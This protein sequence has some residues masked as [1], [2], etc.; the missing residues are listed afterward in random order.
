MLS[1]KSIRNDY[2]GQK[3]GKLTV[4]SFYGY[5][6]SNNKDS[7]WNC[8]CECGRTKVIRI[9]TLK[10]RKLKACGICTQLIGNKHP[11]WKGCGELSKDLY[12]NYKNSAIK[13]GL[14]FTVSIEYL[15]DLFIKQK[16][17]CALTGWE[18]YFPKS[19]KDKKNRTASPDRI[20]NNLGY[21][22][23]NIQWVHRDI[24]YL[25]RDHSLEYF[26]KMCKAVSSQH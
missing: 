22:I 4:V 11:E 12:N 15:W 25:K 3:F 10:K 26:I 24:N 19:Y 16:R 6:M 23:G 5:A 2:S 18:I 14:E 21:V 20:N 1:N 7:L 13:K 17:Q 8:I 9:R